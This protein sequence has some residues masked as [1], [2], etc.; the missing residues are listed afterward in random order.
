MP[1]EIERKFLIQPSAKWREIKNC[2]PGAH[3]QQGY[4]SVGDPEIRIRSSSGYSV[5][6]KMGIKMGSGLTR[7]E[8]EMPVTGEQALDL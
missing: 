3:I 4:I 5:L 7:E 8:I 6:E 1:L 2:P